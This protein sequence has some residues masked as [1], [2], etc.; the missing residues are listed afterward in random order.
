MA[1]VQD[2]IKNFLSGPSKTVIDRILTPEEMKNRDKELQAINERHIKMQKIFTYLRGKE[3]FK[4]NEIA[5]FNKIKEGIKVNEK[6][7]DA[8][9]KE[10]NETIKN[11]KERF[12]ADINTYSEVVD[13]IKK[14]K[15][16]F[17]ED[18]EYEISVNRAREITKH[19][20]TYKEDIE[21]LTKHYEE[22]KDTYEK[23][24]E[25]LKR[26][27]VTIYGKGEDNK[28][29]PLTEKEIGLPEEKDV[30]VKEDPLSEL[31]AIEKNIDLVVYKKG[32]LQRE[33]DA[34][35][36]MK[37]PPLDKVDSVSKKLEELAK[38]FSLLM[39]KEIQSI[40]KAIPIME[41][42]RLG[43]E[44]R[45]P[46]LEKDP[47]KLKTLE[48]NIKS[49]SFQ[50]K[51]LKERIDY[52]EKNDLKNLD[53]YMDER[54][55]SK[56]GPQVKTAAGAEDMGEGGLPSI[57]DKEQPMQKVGPKSMPEYKKVELQTQVP[58]PKVKDWDIVEF[59]FGKEK[60]RA[61]DEIAK[62]QKGIGDIADV[63]V[64]KEIVNEINR[65]QNELERRGKFLDL[66]VK[67]GDKT[68]A[69]K[70]AGKDFRDLLEKYQRAVNDP[71]IKRN[72][73]IPRI[74]KA[75]SRLKA[76]NHYVDETTG[77]FREF[78]KE[79]KDMFVRL[80]YKQLFWD[81]MGYWKRQVGKSVLF[82]GREM[83]PFS[84]V[85]D[86]FKNVAGV[87][88]NPVISAQLNNIANEFRA[89]DT[90][91]T[92]SRFTELK[93]AIK[94]L[95]KGMGL[96]TKGS[97]KYNEY[98][99]EKADKE[100]EI[101][102]LQHLK[103]QK[104]ILM[105]KMMDTADSGF[106]VSVL[107]AINKK[108]GTDNAKE[109]EM[110]ES[111]KKELD[112]KKGDT[113][114]EIQPEPIEKG[115]APTRPEMKMKTPKLDMETLKGRISENLS[116]DQIN[117]IHTV[118]STYKNTQTKEAI[119]QSALE[120]AKETMLTSLDK[121]F[122][123]N[124]MEKTFEQY[125]STISE[126]PEAFKEIMDDLFTTEKDITDS[127]S[128]VVEDIP[129][130]DKA[131]KSLEKA[132]VQISKA[133]EGEDRERLVGQLVDKIEELFESAEQA[134]TFNKVKEMI[135]KD[136]TLF[137]TQLKKRLEKVEEVVKKE[138]YWHDKNFNPKI[139]YGKKM[140][141]V[142]STLLKENQYEDET[143]Q[144]TNT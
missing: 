98:E 64:L 80:F 43:L 112:N 44:D 81:L 117:K 130:P 51:F 5:A 3:Q 87:K 132:T 104:D 77:K 32:Q 66:K 135:Q 76:V 125:K 57:E 129:D 100:K 34:F 1:P 83:A 111:K 2:P 9:L 108:I 17:K 60:A 94:D 22:T 139:L 27:Q 82:G 62:L 54:S 18:K 126:K 136:P 35:K 14:N 123:E 97:A 107:S 142:I 96:A 42:Q 106:L 114:S 124:N 131:I 45:R 28:T 119:P 134:H 56:A 67:I 113:I 141:N 128:K 6:A 15:D 73:L 116:Y 61:S 85:F 12:K 19:I 109:K 10:L 52:I 38:E 78:N 40:K 11:T 95:E 20:K 36:T 47:M 115:K 140:Q 16:N 59:L 74:E 121:I 70:D 41:K 21:S 143:T 29:K 48:S 53:R 49:L 84:R 7:I 99:S 93:E 90:T 69:V 79:E 8:A 13:F 127:I 105:R 92:K 4:E 25:E 58:E 101:E 75:R 71:L 26:I 102:H 122:K 31:R 72:N 89:K 110:I 68:V 46:T 91:Y 50:E 37:T 23:T 86:T 55:K 138:A 144:S 88:S 39:E 133:P 103:K 120:K 24:K 65:K 137:I 30:T 63:E 118:L 33:A